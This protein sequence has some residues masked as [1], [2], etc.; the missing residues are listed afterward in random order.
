MA[1]FTNNN[2]LCVPVM[3]TIRIAIIFLAIFPFLSTSGKDTDIIT[4]SLVQK[5]ESNKWSLKA[6]EKYLNKE[7][8]GIKEREYIIQNHLRTL[9][10]DYNPRVASILFSAL[11]QIK[12]QTGKID[13]SLNLMHKALEYGLLY[14]D[15]N[16][17]I[18][19]HIAFCS[20][21]TSIGQHDLAA[22]YA[23]SSLSDFKSSKRDSAILLRTLGTSKSY[24]GDY[25]SSINYLNIALKLFDQLND[26]QGLGTTYTNLGIVYQKQEQHHKAYECFRKSISMLKQAN[27]EEDLIRTYLNLGNFYLFHQND[28]KKALECF[29]M[30]FENESKYPELSRQTKAG[31]LHNI[32]I[33][34]YNQGRT[35]SCLKW[36]DKA[37]KENITNRNYNNLISN[38]IGLALVY[39]DIDQIDISL[40]YLKKAEDIAI[41]NNIKQNNKDILLRLSQHYEITNN[42]KKALLYRKEYERI[43]DSIAMYN[44]QVEIEK[45]EKNFDLK[46]I[47]EKYNQRLI[48][49]E[50]VRQKENKENKSVIN[51]LKY[52]LFIMFAIFIIVFLSRRSVRRQN[53]LLEEKNREIETQKDVVSKSNSTKRQMLS[54][55]GH[56]LKGPIGTTLQLLKIVKK[57]LSNQ[58]YET[59]STFINE[60]IKTSTGTYSLLE[61][62]LSWAQ[63]VDGKSDIV[64]NTL[65]ANEQINRSISVMINQAQSKDID[66]VSRIPD[67]IYIKADKNMLD[68]IVRNIISNAIKFSNANGRIMLSAKEDD[69]KVFFH[70]T[71]NGV[72]MTEEQVKNIFSGTINKSTFGT[73]NEKGTGLGLELCRLFVE[74]QNGSINILSSKNIGTTIIFSLPK[75]VNDN[76]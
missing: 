45:L 57:Q 44:N 46:R 73:N 35:D 60:L 20:I 21:L 31:T 62:L 68:A 19:N 67:S 55:I 3:K 59:I 12:F 42:Y 11:G 63:G 34:F 4:E 1:I 38:Y 75:A 48:E 58:E 72:G 52:L 53:I 7:F 50:A 8:P 26:L 27:C 13:E 22:E 71:D 65:N 64:I 6:T 2:T 69:D 40:V 47:Q 15:N 28:F 30:L 10:K 54:I 61:N 17:C 29:N 36:Y 16:L 51:L 24:N 74:S 18:E 43:S 49:K 32:A 5:I 76:V 66:I 25:L 39:R 9:D 70:I 14:D 23:K 56:D 41:V 37:V 33:V